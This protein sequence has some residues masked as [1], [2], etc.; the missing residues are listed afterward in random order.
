M[1]LPVAG[2]DIGFVPLTTDAVTLPPQTAK[3]TYTSGSTGS[4]KGVCLSQQQLEAVAVSLVSVIGDEHAGLRDPPLGGSARE[5]RWTVHEHTG[6]RL[7]PCGILKEIGFGRPFQPDI[8]R[9]VNFLADARATSIIMVP[10]ILRALLA[11]ITQR[12][13]SLPNLNLVAVGGARVPP[14]L[15]EAAHA[16][17]PPAFEGY[18]L[19]ECGSVVALNTPAAHR[20]DRAGKVLP[21]LSVSV[22]ADGEIIVGPNPF[23]GYVGGPPACRRRAYRRYRSAR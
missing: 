8:A 5:C 15:V 20:P 19:S 3:V 14:K 4:P 9:L 17:G 16:A 22:A 13:F 18:G 1:S 6:W 11:Y 7:L 23:L 2:D 12:K 21:N 10:E